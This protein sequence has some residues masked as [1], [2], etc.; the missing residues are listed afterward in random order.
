MAAEPHF[1]SIDPEH[2]DPFDATARTDAARFCIFH[3]AAGTPRGLVLHVHAFAEEMNKSRRMAALQSSALGAAGFAV[4]QFDLLGCGDSAGDFGDATWQRWLA[5]VAWAAMHLRRRAS[6]PPGTPV[7]LWGHRVGA[8]L[9]A[10]AADGIGAATGAAPNLL[11]WQPT[12]IGKTALQQFLRL[13]SAA[14]MLDGRGKGV[15]ETLKRELAAGHTVEVAGYRLQPALAAGL[16]AATLD[17]PRQ[18]A[19]AVWLEVASGEVPELMPA[20]HATLQ[21][22]RAAGWTVDASA[23]SGPAFWQTTEIEDAPALVAA[24]TKSMSS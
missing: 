13:K 10:Q 4:L 14:E 22:W 21:R 11:L 9:V 5:D 12:G 17:P 7:W 16:E 15:V 2:D 20:S 18:A 6:A 24:S 1:A 3:P 23:V 8:L 19:H